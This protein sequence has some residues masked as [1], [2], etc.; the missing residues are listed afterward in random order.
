MEAE[1]SGFATDIKYK[2]AADALQCNWSEGISETN[3]KL[4]IPC[5]K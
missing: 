1:Q 2:Q 4:Q 5:S 3:F